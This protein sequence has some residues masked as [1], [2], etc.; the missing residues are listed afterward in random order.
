[1]VP[2]QVEVLFVVDNTRGNSLCISKGSAE[3]SRDRVTVSKRAERVKAWL[4]FWE[5]SGWLQ[6]RLQFI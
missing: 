1:M 6:S 5:D 3:V 4:K 2:P